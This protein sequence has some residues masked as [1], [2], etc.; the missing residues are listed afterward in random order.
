LMVTMAA[1]ARAV[2][3]RL[4]LARAPAASEAIAR[5]LHAGSKGR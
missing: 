4:G 3:P 5:P 1:L 2:H